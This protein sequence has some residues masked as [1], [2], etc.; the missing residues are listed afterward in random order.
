[1]LRLISRTMIAWLLVASCASGPPMTIAE[2]D[3][4]ARQYEATAASIEHEC[5]KHLRHELTVDTMTPCWKAEDVRFLQANLDAAARH[6]AEA[7]RLRDA[8][9]TAQR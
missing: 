8:Q 5:A 7:Q 3:E 9:A 4:A 1:M 2:H 6:R